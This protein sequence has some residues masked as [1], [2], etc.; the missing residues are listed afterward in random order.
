M[1]REGCWI[2]GPGESAHGSN[3][4][5]PSCRR[6]LRWS[7]MIDR[8]HGRSRPAGLQ[9]RPEQRCWTVKPQPISQRNDLV[10]LSISTM[11]VFS[12]PCDWLGHINIE[13]GKLN[14][15][16]RFFD[17]LEYFLACFSEKPH[18]GSRSLVCK[19]NTG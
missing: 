3:P 17:L 8:R 19:E 10:P 2:S 12:Q 1:N 6:I 15:I 11:G 9:R 4:D 18:A 14:V 13:V 7:G 16:E 5:S